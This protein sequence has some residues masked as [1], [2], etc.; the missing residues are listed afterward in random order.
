MSH[1]PVIIA[2]GETVLF[3]LAVNKYLEGGN[4]S[5]SMLSRQD[6]GYVPYAKL[7]I[8]IPNAPELEPNQ[9]IIKDYSE[10]QVVVEQLVLHKYLKELGQFVDGFP[11]MELTDK[12]LN[13]TNKDK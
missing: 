2:H 11:I 3:R 4:P 9:F 12:A 13:V 7:S 6:E 5:L 1:I 10:N 8:N